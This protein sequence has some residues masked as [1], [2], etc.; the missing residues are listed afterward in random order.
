MGCGSYQPIDT[1]IEASSSA[2]PIYTDPTQ[3]L[4]K[5]LKFKW[6]LAQGESGEGQRDYMRTAGS[7]MTRIWGGIKGAV[8]HMEHVNYV[9]PKSLNGGEIV[10]S[11]GGSCNFQGEE[12]RADKNRR[13]MRVHPPNAEHRRPHQC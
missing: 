6:T 9:G 8:S 7:T 5:I 2:Y 1:Y 10:L 13:Q 12:A 4:H 11:A 3:R